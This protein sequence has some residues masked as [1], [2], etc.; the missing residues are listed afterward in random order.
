[1]IYILAGRHEAIRVISKPIYIGNAQVLQYAGGKNGERF[2]ISFFILPK[3]ARAFNAFM[4]RA[5]A[6]ILDMILDKMPDIIGRFTVECFL[7]ND[8][9]NLK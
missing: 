5:V 2:A 8:G 9:Q 1:M 3:L 7:L 6:L 4:P